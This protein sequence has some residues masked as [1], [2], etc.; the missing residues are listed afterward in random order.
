MELLL[1]EV[2]YDG[3]TGKVV[4]TFNPNGIQALSNQEAVA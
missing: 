4:I 3:R 1:K 2:A